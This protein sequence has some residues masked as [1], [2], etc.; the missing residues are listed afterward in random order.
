MPNIRHSTDLLRP[1]AAW[2]APP[3]PALPPAASLR[4]CCGLLPCLL[5]SA[6]P[7]CRAANLDANTR[8][9][10]KRKPTGFVCVCVCE[11]ERERERE[12]EIVS[13]RDKKEVKGM[14]KA[15]TCDI[16]ATCVSCAGLRM[17]GR[18]PHAAACRE[19]DSYFAPSSR[20]RKRQIQGTAMCRSHLLHRPMDSA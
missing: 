14:R 7:S 9:G 11:R 5:A 20:S 17:P 8:A 12:R 1:D 3:S 16:H 4:P 6:G 18:R 19:I 15:H 13:E 10:R 2:L